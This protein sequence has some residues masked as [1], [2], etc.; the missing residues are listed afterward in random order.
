MHNCDEFTPLMTAAW[1]GKENAFRGL[2]SQHKDTTGKLAT[3]TI[4]KQFSETTTNG[5]TVIHIAVFYLQY[6]ILNIII[7]YLN[8][9]DKK[10]RKEIINQ[11]EFIHNRTPYT[12]L[13]AYL[14]RFQYKLEFERDTAHLQP[15]S[16]IFTIAASVH[17]IQD[18]TENEQDGNMAILNTKEKIGKT[19]EILIKM[20]ECNVLVSDNMDTLGYEYLQMMGDEA[21]QVIGNDLMNKLAKHQQREKRMKYVR[22][23]VTFIK[24]F[25]LRL[26]VF[27]WAFLLSSILVVS[28]V[29]ALIYMI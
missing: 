21:K 22:P 24:N 19:F 14:Y 23:V 11:H 20:Q 26:C 15:Q 1:L 28:G 7:E 8:K 27:M 17:D 5:L 6:K 16:N 18:R 4:M 9:L 25:W 3:N 29:V 12:Y 13:C 2:C 10:T